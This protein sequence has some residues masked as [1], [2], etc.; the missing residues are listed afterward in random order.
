M[1]GQDGG[2]CNGVVNEVS[3]W[4]TPGVVVL[5]AAEDTHEQDEQN[6][7]DEGGEELLGVDLDGGEGGDVDVEGGKDEPADECADKAD[8][9]VDECI[10]ASAAHDAG[11]GGTSLQ[12]YDDPDDEVWNGD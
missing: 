6:G 9:G 8:E 2:L 1:K 4:P 11:G 3:G 7:P 12:A 5:G 10:A